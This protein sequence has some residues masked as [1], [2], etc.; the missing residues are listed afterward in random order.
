MSR[1]ACARCGCAYHECECPSVTPAGDNK[2]PVMQIE[3][4]P[5]CGVPAHPGE[6]DDYG[7]CVDCAY[8]MHVVID[9]KRVEITA[10]EMRDGEKRD[11]AVLSPAA[12]ERVVRGIRKYLRAAST[13]IAMANVGTK[14]QLAQPCNECG[15]AVSYA[16]WNTHTCRPED[17]AKYAALLDERRDAREVHVSNEAVW[18][19]KEGK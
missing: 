3:H 14:R 19:D 18:I 13:S 12:R 5:V 1:G 8:H 4:C 2:E 10:I 17:R 7:R 16:D 11:P 6:S 15:V 9:G